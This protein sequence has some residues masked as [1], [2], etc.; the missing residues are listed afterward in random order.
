MHISVPYKAL[1]TGTTAATYVNTVDLP[2]ANL[3]RGEGFH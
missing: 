3:Y 2:L 1:L